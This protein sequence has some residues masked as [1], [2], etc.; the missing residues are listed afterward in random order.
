[1]KTDTATAQRAQTFAT[2]ELEYTDT[3]GGEANYCWCKRATITAP[4]SI[5][6]RALIR[7]AKSAL[8]ITGRHRTESYGETIA[9]YPRGSCTVLFINLQY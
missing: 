9:I 3:F 8:G 2:F 4:E 7:R 5:T 6:G 1:M